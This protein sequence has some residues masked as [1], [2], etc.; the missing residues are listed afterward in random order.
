MKCAC[1]SNKCPIELHIQGNELWFTSKT[2]ETTLMYLDAN[3]LL[4][5]IKEA[6]EALGKLVNERR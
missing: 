4:E 1:G 2:N 3:I 6:Q 5:L